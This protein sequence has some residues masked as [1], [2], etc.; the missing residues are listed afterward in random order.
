[1]HEMSLAESM[2]EIIEAEAARQRFGRVKTVVLELG[3]L[4][5]VDPHAMTFCFAAVTRGT[6]AEGARLEI[7]AMPGTAWCMDCAKPVEVATRLDAC[8]LCGGQAL[9]VTGGTELRLRELEVE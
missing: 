7:V 1:M 5:H 9:Q 3:A 8:P 2:V 6:V 4:G